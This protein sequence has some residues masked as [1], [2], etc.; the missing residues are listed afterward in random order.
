MQ[1]RTDARWAGFVLLA[2]T[3]VGWGLNW[4]FIKL[5]LRDWPPLFSRG[6]S[7]VAAAVILAAVASARGESL[8]VPRSVVPALLV[9]A[10][11]NVFAWM[12]FGTAA[13]VDLSISEG[14]LLVYTMPIWAMLFAWPLLGARP[15]ARDVVALL[16]GLAGILVLF[17]GGQFAFSAGKLGG[18]ALALSSA[19][20][21]A[22]GSVR[23]RAPLPIDP[24]ALVAWQVGLG[25]APMVLFGLAFEQPDVAALSRTGLTVLIYMTLVP[26]GLCYLTW[27]AALQRLPASTA[28]MGTLI[29]PLIGVVAAALL[30]GE[31]L[32][33]REILAAALT[34]GGVALAIKR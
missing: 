9:A 1:N 11:T 5:L 34:L 24:I 13:M 27:F 14:T 30:L 16:L 19:I 33:T 25:C 22:L 23:T 15:R 18:I 31:P 2:V 32:G 4:A 7:G 12:G 17:A 28:A 20:L 21:F 8:K 6:V 3:A 29:V 10:F 26:M